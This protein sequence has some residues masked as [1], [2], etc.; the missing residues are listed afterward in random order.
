MRF[1]TPLCLAASLVVTSTL[2]AAW[3]AVAPMD[4]SRV[5]VDDFDDAEL[6]VPLLLHH[7]AQ[8]A[9]AVVEEGPNR[10][11]LNIKIN[12]EPKDNEPY[13]A[14]IQENALSLAYFYTTD[15]PWNPYHGDAAVRVRL[16]AMLEFW[17]K[18]QHPE[19]G[20]FSEYGPTNFSLAPTGFGI[21]HMARVLDLL[22]TKNGPKIDSAVFDR[23]MAAQRKAILSMLTRDDVFGWGSGWSNQWS[24]VLLAASTYLTMRPDDAELRAAFLPAVERAAK[25]FQSPAGYLYES[26]GPDIGYS[27]VHETN[28]RLAW[29]KLAKFPDV[30]DAIVKE[31]ERYARF[32]AHQSVPQPGTT[33]LWTN[34]GVNTRT[35]HSHQRPKVRPIAELSTL[36]RALTMS[37]EELAADNQRKRD[38]LRKTW[39][40]FRPLTIPSAYSYIPTPLFTAEKGYVPWCPTPVQ[41][42][43]AR[44]QLPCND[45]SPFTRIAHDAKHNFGF[46]YVNRP[47]AYYAVFNYGKPAKPHTLGLGL[48]WNARYGVALQTV[49]NSEWK[50]GT[51]VGEKLVREQQPL[52]PKWT[53]A[54]SEQPAP[55]PGYADLPTG[56]AVA[57]FDLPGGGTKTVAFAGDQI[58]VT[59]KASG[60]IVERLPLLLA[61]GDSTKVTGPELL[62]VRGAN[63]FAI[64]AEGATLKLTNNDLDRAQLTLEAKDRLIYTLSFDGAK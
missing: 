23:T 6:D 59:V 20:L 40:E 25:T 46:V 53:I 56:D 21:M 32:V 62:V 49:A 14:R 16:E 11:F 13:N 19:T 52:Y 55:Q 36:S 12:R 50:C 3:P 33:L 28:V 35:Q 9:N 31:D 5:S 34:A 41:R 7:F 42:A 43:E 45:P 44:A 24:G 22:G 17:C 57:A 64:R 2:H 63:R 26:H 58:T 48:L 4:W 1:I 18:I 51:V 54:G 30:R 15:R 38:T 37:T 8:V 47:N 29:Q 10:G 27:S 60:V 39:P 61:P